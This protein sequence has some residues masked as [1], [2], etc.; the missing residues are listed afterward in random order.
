MSKCFGLRDGGRFVCRFFQSA[1]LVLGLGA[2]VIAN[3]ETP[4]ACVEALPPVWVEGGRFTLG[5]NETYREEAAANEVDVSGFWMDPT[6]VTVG[7]FD[8]FVKATG[9]VTIGERGLDEDDV[10]A[11][12]LKA[13]PQ[14]RELM[15]P[16]GAVFK[17]NARSSLRNANWWAFVPDANWRYPEG[18]DE[19]AAEPSHP[20]TQI[21]YEDAAQYAAWVGGRLPSEAEWEYA[22]LAGQSNEEFGS[23]PPSEANTWQ[24]IFP[25]INTADDGFAE[26]APVGCFAP[27]QNGLYDMLGNVWEWTADPYAPGHATHRPDAPS[28]AEKESSVSTPDE[29]P[30]RVIKGGSFLCAAN[31][32]RRYRPAARQPQETGLGTNH[33]GFR[34]VYDRPPPAESQSKQ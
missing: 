34:V 26:V 16:G 23:A 25:V 22:A 13:Y 6:E 19:V 7:D 2:P 12:I 3:A 10:D 24:G 30:A 21:A 9:Y 18:P 15:V 8:K 32:C 27:N 4:A 17:P 1:M 31:Y 20:V 14:Y 33:I 29:P 5:S 11:E 28:S